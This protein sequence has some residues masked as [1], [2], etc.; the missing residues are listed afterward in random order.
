MTELEARPA[1]AETVLDDLTRDR[2]ARA[3]PPNTTA[4]YTVVREQFEAWCDQQGRT[5]LPATEQ[6]LT[7]YVS[8]M[9]TAG[10]APAS[11]AQHVGAIRTRHRLAGF[12][13]QPDTS[14][15][16]LL[17]RGYRRDR[18]AEGQGERQATPFT[19][20][21]LRAVIDTLDLV[22]TT[23]RRDQLLLVLGFAGMLRR[24]ELAALDVSDVVTVPEGIEVT[25]R[26]SKTDKDSQGRV[27]ALPPASHPD[28]D[29]VALTAAWKAFL[30]AYGAPG[31]PLLRR[32]TRDGHLTDRRMR[33][34]AMNEVV[35]RL[36]RDAGLPDPKGYSAHSLRAGGLTAS[37]RAGVPLGVAARH[38]GWNPESPT[39]HRYARAADRWRDNAMRGVL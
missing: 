32:V 25:V 14:R 34:A 31:G 23:G 15:V 21:S 28:V 38:G 24:S 29:P 17:I 2:L 30:A 18:A 3:I 8:H 27:T 5:A 4:A 37:L 20:D 26:M 19:P 7:A 6:T 12:P 22:S 33:P 16:R 10:R 9:I 1:A 36:V 13:G 35:Q 39:P 11:I